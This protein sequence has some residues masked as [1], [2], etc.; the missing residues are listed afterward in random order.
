MDVPEG[1]L[2][3]DADTR[4]LTYADG[5]RADVIAD[6]AVPELLALVAAAPGELSHNAAV[7]QLGADHGIPQAVAR[8]AIRRATRPGGELTETLGPNRS[9]LMSP[10]P[11]LSVPGPVNGQP[12]NG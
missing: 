11:D 3:L 8:A 7:R 6:A 5:T 1:L 9:R 4:H 12:V 2:T 10:A